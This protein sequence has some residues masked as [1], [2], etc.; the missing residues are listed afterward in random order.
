MHS[1]ADLRCSVPQCDHLMSV[2]F[3]SKRLDS[4]SKTEVCNLDAAVRIDK[5]ILWLQVSMEDPS[6]VTEQ[7]ALQ[8]LK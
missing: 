1:N 3:I 6:L 4:A 5:K 2:D 7:D 8:N